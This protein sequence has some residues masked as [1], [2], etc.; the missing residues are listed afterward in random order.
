MLSKIASADAFLASSVFSLGE[1]RKKTK[2]QVYSVSFF[3]SFFLAPFF[4]SSFT[5][6]FDAVHW[7]LCGCE[8]LFF[9][10]LSFLFFRYISSIGDLSTSLHTVFVEKREEWSRF[11]HK[12]TDAQTLCVQKAREKER[13]KKKTNDQRVNLAQGK[14][15]VNVIS[16]NDINHVFHLQT[17]YMRWSE[18]YFVC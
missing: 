17:F 14:R 8:G 3:S 1:W 9:F 10:S 5:L 11:N 15:K 4:C 12:Q 2:S 16:P 13:E 6:A 18:L 7:F